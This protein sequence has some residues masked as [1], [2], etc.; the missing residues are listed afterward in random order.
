MMRNLLT[1]QFKSRFFVYV[2]VGFSEQW[3]EWFFWITNC[4]GINYKK[5]RKNVTTLQRFIFF[6]V[7]FVE[8]VQIFNEFDCFLQKR[9][10]HI[11]INRHCY[12]S[13]IFSYEFFEEFPDGH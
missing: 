8:N 7:G 12:F 13:D 4:I 9:N 3:I 2:F 11:E 10:R 6:L 5:Y 1:N